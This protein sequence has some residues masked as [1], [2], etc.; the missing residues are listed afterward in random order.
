MSAP[1]RTQR[2]L[3]S[4]VGVRTPR[5]R[6]FS[7]SF[8]WGYSVAHQASA[9]LNSLAARPPCR[10]LKARRRSARPRLTRARG[11]RYR[12]VSPSDRP[13]ESTSDLGADANR[14]FGTASSRPPRGS[15]WLW[16]W[17]KNA[18]NL[19]IRWFRRCTGWLNATQTGSNGRQHP[20]HTWIGRLVQGSG[21]ASR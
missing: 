12:A 21:L 17:R 14:E 10:L 5:R 8:G 19:R 18:E 15:R 16:K 2:E 6:G 20:V 3:R 7:A 1:S 4:P 9:H 11:V 13:W